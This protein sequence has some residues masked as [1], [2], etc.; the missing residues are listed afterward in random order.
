MQ[1]AAVQAVD[2]DDPQREIK[3]LYVSS[4]AR[5]V[6]F[7]IDFGQNGGP[8]D[9][10]KT[11]AMILLDTIPNQGQHRI[12]GGSGLTT[13]AGIDFAI[14]LRGPK[15]SRIWVDSNYDS[16]YYEYGSRLHMM[17]HLDY[18]N[19]K[20]NGVFHKM[21][22]V[23]NK[24]MDVP[25]VRG[26]TLHLPLETYETG[27]LRYGNGNPD[28]PDFDSLAD[29]AY[30]DKEHTVEIRIPWQLLNVK[31]PSSREIMGDLWKNGLQASE[32]IPGFKLAVLSYRPDGQGEPNAPGSGQI[33]YSM[34]GITGGVLQ[35]KDMFTY[36]WDKW[37]AINYY[38]R[39]KKSYYILQDL[40]QKTE[41]T[42]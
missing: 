21:T 29:V 31:D 14:D 24:G 17:P 33:A 38:E 18:A 37:E 39:L 8:I 30:N 20:D 11:G 36:Q 7:R 28:S 22:L 4:D 42:K 41:L 2:G 5:N 19:K 1:A 16:T 3:Q 34:P 9:W 26:Q 35:S 40:F 15:Q 23:L 25:N 32:E 12:P 27:L 6:Y 13:D 10:A